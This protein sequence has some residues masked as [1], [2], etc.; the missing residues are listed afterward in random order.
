M[1]R[2][3]KQESDRETAVELQLAAV[4]QARWDA[5]TLA[6][7]APRRKPQQFDNG[8]NTLQ[9][10]CVEGMDCLPGQLDLF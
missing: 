7:D 9:R 3:N 1:S 10:V 4:R 5:F 2:P 6:N 8:S